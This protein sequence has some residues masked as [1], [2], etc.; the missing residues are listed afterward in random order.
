M[1]DIAAT[2]QRIV[3]QP[4]FAGLLFSAFALG[5]GFSFVSPFLSLWGTEEIG[6]RPVALGLYI[7]K[8][9]SVVR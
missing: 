3:R 9:R 7:L 1:R 5:L 4:G 2:A 8:K 6:L